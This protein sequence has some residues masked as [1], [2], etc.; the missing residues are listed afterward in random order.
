MGLWIGAFDAALG[1]N[2]LAGPWQLNLVLLAASVLTPAILVTL[3]FALCWVPARLG[4]HRSEFTQLA[5][6]R[7]LMLPLLIGGLAFFLGR[8]AGVKTPVVVSLAATALAVAL[9]PVVLR[10]S[11]ARWLAV[12]ERCA[13]NPKTVAA[14]PLLVIGLA[15]THAPHGAQ[16]IAAGP[17]NVALISVDTMRADHL[18]A[19]GY[20]RDTSPNLDRLAARGVRFSEAYAASWWTLPSHASMLTGLGPLAHGVRKPGQRLSEQI[21]TVAE[22]LRDQGYDTAA[23]VGMG[24]YSFVGSETGLAQGFARYQHPPYPVVPG[25][26]LRELVQL[27]GYWIRG[28]VGVLEGQVDAALRWITS[29]RRPWFLFLHTYEVHSRPH[30]LPYA[31]PA[32]Y[33]GQYCDTPRLRDAIRGGPTGSDLLL[34][35]NRTPPSAEA[36]AEAVCLYDGAIAY[37]DAQIARLVAAIESHAPNTL[38]IVTSDHGEEF[39]EHGKFLHRDFFEEVWR[40][41]LIVRGPGISGGLVVDGPVQNWDLAALMLEAAGLPTPRNALR[42]AI[43]QPKTRSEDERRALAVSYDTRALAVGRHRYFER[44]GRSEMYDVAEDPFQRDELLRNHPKRRGPFRRRLRDME[45]LQQVELDRH[46][47]SPEA[48]ELPLEEVRRLRSLGY[49]E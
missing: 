6:T 25:S 9:A 35:W 29:R 33:D 32:P 39:G 8:Q 19:Y 11:S 41:P 40:V 45:R 4:S 7:T 37:V 22:R 42:S 46:G 10:L 15:V 23:L 12:G 28:F 44:Y 14:V 30:G 47:A 16:E 24:R 20:H 2:V 48:L 49:V 5:W 3:A 13:R 1:A 27:Y 18:G 26:L 36:L 34:A 17:P 21:A 43:E 31:A 38:I